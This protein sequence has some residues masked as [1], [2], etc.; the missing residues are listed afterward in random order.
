MTR[1]R[2][3]TVFVGDARGRT[4]EPADAV[5]TIILH[6][7]K[8]GTIGSTVV[9]REDAELAWRELG[10]I[11]GKTEATRLRIT[12]GGDLMPPLIE[13]VYE[14]DLVDIIQ[15]EAEPEISLKTNDQELPVTFSVG[16]WLRIEKP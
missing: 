10:R 1:A 14:G 2:C 11:L 15:T 3:G 7:P 8:G 13:R 5:A 12:T 6:G 16:P 4:G 9:D